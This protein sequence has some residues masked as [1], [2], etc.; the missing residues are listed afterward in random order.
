[1]CIDILSRKLYLQTLMNKQSNTVIEAFKKIFKIAKP[2]ILRADS[3]SKFYNRLIKKYLKDLNIKH[4]IARNSTKENYVERV[5]KTFL[6][7]SLLKDKFARAYDQQWSS[8]IFIV[9]DRYRSQGIP[10]YKLKQYDGEP[11]F[12]S[13]YTSEL[14]R[15]NPNADTLWEIDKIIKYRGSG[16]NREALVSLKG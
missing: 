16:K 1:M 14:L 2:E 10:L 15:L 4:I 8:E 7:I 11:L 9:S 3:G 12:G 13:F 5:N 6:R